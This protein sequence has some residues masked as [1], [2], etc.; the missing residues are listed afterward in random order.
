[1]VD[2]EARQPNDG[3]SLDQ[4]PE[5]GRAMSVARARGAVVLVVGERHVDYIE[6]PGSGRPRTRRSLVR[7]IHR[8]RRSRRGAAVAK[9]A[10]PITLA[11]GSSSPPPSAC[12]SC[13]R[14]QR[15][16]PCGGFASIAWLIRR[17][18]GTALAQPTPVTCT[19]RS[20]ARVVVL[21]QSV[22]KRRCADGVDARGDQVSISCRSIASRRSSPRLLEE[23]LLRGVSAPCSSTRHLAR[24]SPARDAPRRSVEDPSAKG[25]PAIPSATRTSRWLNVRAAAPL[26]AR[27]FAARAS[28]VA[29]AGATLRTAREARAE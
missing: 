9:I 23:V 6:R 3:G 14:P 13:S 12:R 8:P 17:N 26:E 25:S 24:A 20:S 16:D 1:V 7:R 18:S 11:R 5:T 21:D 4:V 2:R 15:R 29:S 28:N 10:E 27:R 22:G 19:C